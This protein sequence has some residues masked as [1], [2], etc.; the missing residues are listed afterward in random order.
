MV[1]W[2]VWTPTANRCRATPATLIFTTT[3][4]VLLVQAMGTARAVARRITKL[5]FLFIASMFVFL[6]RAVRAAASKAG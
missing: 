6:G 1:A 2:A 3:V 5:T 4:A